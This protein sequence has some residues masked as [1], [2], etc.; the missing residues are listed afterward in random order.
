MEELGM[1]FL[2]RWHCV[3]CLEFCVL[4]HR[5]RMERNGN[6][7]E[8]SCSCFSVKDEAGAVDFGPSRHFRCVLVLCAL[9][10]GCPGIYA[11][12]VP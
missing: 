11:G 8:T 3:H 2:R 10:C 1:C 4:K 5:D 6:L 9:I 12:R 7:N